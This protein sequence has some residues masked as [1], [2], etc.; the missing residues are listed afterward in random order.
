MKKIFL[1]IAMVAAFTAVQAQKIKGSDTCLPLSQQEAEDFMKANPSKSVVVTGGGSGVGIAALIEGTTDIAQSSRKIKFD[2]KQKIQAGGKS[3]KEVIIAYDALAVIVNPKNK[4]TNLT[5][6]QLEKIFTGKITNWK[7]VGGA[8]L[9]IVPYS[10]ETSSGTYE[11]FKESVLKNKNYKSGIMSMPATG[12]I[13][14]AIGQTAG[15]IG[16]VGLAY[17]DKNTKAIRVSY[18]GGKTFTAPSAANAKNGSYPIVRPLYYYYLTNTEKTAKPF[19]DYVLS[20]KGQKT[21]SETG[22]ISVK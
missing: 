20:A 1:A 3:I 15:A 17:V 22:F 16:Y 5:R 8:D 2:E 11:F 7:E 6:E 19:I 10:R 14:Q 9:K 12:A 4:V 13:V 21:V 18:D